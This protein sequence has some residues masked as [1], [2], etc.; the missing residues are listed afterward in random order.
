MIALAKH[1][2]NA[3]IDLCWSWIINPAASVRF[4]KEMLMAAPVSKVFTFGGD[5]APVEPI[6]GHAK[7]ARQGIAQ[8]VSE[9]VHENWLPVPDAPSVIERIMR[10]NQ[11][12]V[13]QIEEKKKAQLSATSQATTQ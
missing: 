7:I 11:C 2:R 13:F 12:E 4:L 8:A 9:L 3:Y 6:V 10:G 5:Y 1:Y